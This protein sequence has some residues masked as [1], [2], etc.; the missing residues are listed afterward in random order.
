MHRYVLGSTALALFACGGQAS[1]NEPV[2]DPMLTSGG[3]LGSGG[4]T[5]LGSG[6]VVTSSSGGVVTNSSGGAVTNAGGSPAGGELECPDLR[7]DFAALNPA[8]T[9]TGSGVTVEPLQ[10]PN[11]RGTTYAPYHGPRNPDPSTW[12]RSALPAGACVYRLHGVNAACFPL[13]GSLWVGTCAE[14]ASG[15]SVLPFSFYEMYG[16]HGVA[17]GCPTSD[18]SV[19]APGNWWY[20]NAVSPTEADL[21]ICAPECNMA[22]QGA[23]CLVLHDSRSRCL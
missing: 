5:S 10:V 6:G 2:T 8:V 13:G 23:A 11:Y 12:D 7:F 3:A 14:L 18:S 9:V 15:M 22:Y 17:P 19:D 1:K 21:V 20:L 4:V 16:C